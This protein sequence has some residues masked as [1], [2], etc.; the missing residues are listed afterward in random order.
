MVG[1]IN[2][3]ANRTNLLALNAAV[4]AAHAGDAGRGFAVVA[5]EIRKLAVRTTESTGQIAGEVRT[6]RDTVASNVLAI[7]DIAKA[8]AEVSDQARGIASTAEQQGEVTQSIAGQMADTATRVAEVDSTIAQVEV[9]SSHAASAAGQ[10][11]AGM[12]H[13]DHASDQM[14]STMTS[15]VSRVRNL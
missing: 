6:V 7:R 3:I 5:G 12:T 2:D 14:D 10:V 11:L 8:I 13:V 4:E 1:L 9:A 15:F